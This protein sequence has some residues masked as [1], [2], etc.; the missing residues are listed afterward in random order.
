[1]LDKIRRNLN[2]LTYPVE[3]KD[4]MCLCA[5]YEIGGHLAILNQPY[6]NRITEKDKTIESRFSK[7]GRGPFKLEKI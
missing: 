7:T 4:L 1:M 2:D 5:E 3:I 6:L